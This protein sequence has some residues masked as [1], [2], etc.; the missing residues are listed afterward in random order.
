MAGGAQISVLVVL[1]DAGHVVLGR[2]LLVH[3]IEIEVRI[4]VLTSGLEVI[5]ENTFETTVTRR[6]EA[7][8]VQCVGRTI[9]N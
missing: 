6:S 1:R 7:Q 5:S 8:V 4:V 9:W 3:R 2:F